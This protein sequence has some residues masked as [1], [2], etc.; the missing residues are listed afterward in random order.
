MLPVYSELVNPVKRRLLSI[1]T[2]T[3]S[4]ILILYLV[5]SL[6][7][8]F[9]TLNN[10]PEVVLLRPPPIPDWGTDWLM[11][12]ASIL[13]L[14]TMIANIVLNYMPFRNSLYFMMTGK[15][16]FSQKYNL[17]TTASFQAACCA[18]S[19]VYPSVSNV[20][21][22]FGGIASVNIVYIVPRKSK[23]LFSHL[24]FYIV[25]VYCYLKLRREDDPLT[26]MKNVSAMIYF[27]IMCLIGWLSSAG[28]VAMMLGPKDS[29]FLYC[30]TL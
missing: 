19:I 20:L 17:I 9:A 8:Y 29:A 3:L 28:T 24:T 21:A 11:Q 2:R 13:V 18:M 30:Q 16:D 12:V 15:E 25:V 22:I 23:K 5:M 10:T 6:T 26:S 4:L 1:I 7:G 14:S 27:G